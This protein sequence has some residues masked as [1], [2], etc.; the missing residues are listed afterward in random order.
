MFL[1]YYFYYWLQVSASI[2]HQQANIYKNSSI[3]WDP[4]HMCEWDP[5]KLKS[6]NMH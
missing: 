6:Y 5:I 4:F 2:G 3:L 1:F